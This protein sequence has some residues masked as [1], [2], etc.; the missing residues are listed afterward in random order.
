MAGRTSPVP[1]RAA[2]LAEAALTAAGA[3]QHDRA[4]ILWRVRVHPAILRVENLEKSFASV[5]LGRARF[6][7]DL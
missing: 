5:S 4:A 7:T 3:R 6:R 2:P 1:A